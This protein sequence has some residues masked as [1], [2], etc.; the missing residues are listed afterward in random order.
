MGGGKGR[1]GGC[2]RRGGTGYDGFDWIPVLLDM[3]KRTGSF[4]Y[5]DFDRIPPPPIYTMVLDLDLDISDPGPPHFI[6][7][8]GRRIPG[9]ALGPS[10]AVWM[11][12]WGCFRTV[13][14]RLLAVRELPRTKTANQPSSQPTD[15]K[16]NRTIL[17]LGL[18]E[19]AE[20]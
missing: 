8:Y 6:Q 14:G 11:P 3:M 7:S 20:R 1:A 18:V 13:W 4:G 17:K 10:W 5:D 16:D 2:R 15:Q 9:S 12:C 19:C